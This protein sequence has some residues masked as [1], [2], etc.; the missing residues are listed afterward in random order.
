MDTGNSGFLSP[1]LALDVS[2][3]R[4]SPQRASWSTVA[5][6]SACR[7]S[8]RN[9]FRST[10]RSACI[11]VPRVVLFSWPRMNEDRGQRATRAR[12]VLAPKA[13]HNIARGKRAGQRPLSAAPGTRTPAEHNAEGVA[14]CGRT[15]DAAD[16]GRPYGAFVPAA[17]YRPLSPS[18]ESQS[19]VALTIRNLMPHAVDTRRTCP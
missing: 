6:P 15:A 5:H 13:Q 3:G 18:P 12:F 17:T 16:G 10:P 4:S 19:G 2:S 9:Q 14:Q 7:H 1:P 8:E 11:R